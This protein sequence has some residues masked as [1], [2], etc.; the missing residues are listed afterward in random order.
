MERVKRFREYH[1]FQDFVFHYFKDTQEDSDLAPFAGFQREAIDYMLSGQKTRQ[2]WEWFRGCGKSMLGTLY[3]PMWLALNRKLKGMIIMSH[4]ADHA[5][6]L[7]RDFFSHITENGRIHADY[8]KPKV[9]GTPGIGA[10]LVSFND[11]YMFS[12]W[13]RGVEQNPAGLKTGANRPNY[14]VVDDADSSICAG[15]PRIVGQR[16]KHIK[17]TLAGCTGVPTRTP[18]MFIYSNNRV[19]PHGLTAAIVDEMTKKRQ[20]NP[21]VQANYHYSKV[22]ITIDKITKE[23]KTIEEGGVPAWPE[24]MTEEFVYSKNRRYDAR[25][26]QHAVVP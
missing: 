17:G 6:F 13:G 14:I 15:N 19:H 26:S 24:Y 16:L 5:Q 10:F 23:P 18:N 1:R 11:G 7:M 21:F 2:I 20:D 3:I 8:G 9:S 12:V 4:A 22:A 25:R